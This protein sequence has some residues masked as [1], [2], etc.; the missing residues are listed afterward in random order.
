MVSLIQKGSFL[1]SYPH[2]FHGAV[3]IS[4]ARILRAIRIAARLGF[5]F[6]K[7]TAHSIKDL[8][9]SIMRLDKVCVTIQIFL[10]FIALNFFSLL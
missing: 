2:I 7:E 9:N 1:K 5:R 10:R 8:A 3:I 4:T 6:S